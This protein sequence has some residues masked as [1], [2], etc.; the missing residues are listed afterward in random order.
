MNM[1]VAV[2]SAWGIGKNNDLPWRLSKEF[3]HF[4]RQTLKTEDP[5]KKNAVIM[6][7]RCWESIPP[8]FR[9]LHDR[10]NVIVSKTME[11]KI[12]E[13]IIVSNDFDDALRLL[14]ED[15]RF[16]DRIETIWNVGGTE[17]YT[18]GLK[19]SLMWKLVLTRL[20][21]S[22]DCDRKFPEVNWDEFEKNLDFSEETFEEVEKN[23]QKIVKYQ[24]TSYT[25]K[26]VK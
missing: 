20:D 8:K 22:F 14:T 13:D 19:H 26:L 4:V 18:L 17:I 3:A 6:G 21:T 25:K 5:N 24:I 9:P 12:S 16:K 15:E 10:V 2:D 23:T 1:I 11:P 7:R